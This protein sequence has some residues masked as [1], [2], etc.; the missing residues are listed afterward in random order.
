MEEARCFSGPFSFAPDGYADPRKPTKIHHSRF[1][2][3]DDDV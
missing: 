3:N 1:R 2:G